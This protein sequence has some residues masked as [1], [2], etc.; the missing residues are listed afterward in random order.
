VSRT[1]DPALLDGVAQGRIEAAAG[2]GK[3]E[4][5]V[6]LTSI[7]GGK[8]TLI[9][10]HT[11]AG[12]AALRRRLQSAGVPTNRYALSS[13]DAWCVRRVSEF[14]LRAGPMPD[15]SNSRVFYPAVRNACLSLLA[16]HAL[17]AALISSYGRV[18]V[19]EYQDCGPDQH[20]IVCALTKLVP[21]FVFGDPLQAVFDFPGSPVVVW[22]RDVAPVFPLL[23]TLDHPWRWIRAGAVELGQWLSRARVLLGDG[24][25]IDLQDLPEGC[26][27]RQ[28]SGDV[29]RDTQAVRTATSYW[30]R[31]DGSVLVLANPTQPRRHADIARTGDGIQVVEN[32]DLRTVIQAMARL[33]QAPAPERLRLLLDLAHSVMTGIPVNDLIRRCDVL[34]RGRSR[35]PPTADE[36]IALEFALQADWPNAE[37]ALRRWAVQ[38]GRR[39]FRREV[40]RMLLDC[41]RST[42]TGRQPSLEE[43]M[44]SARERRRHQGRSTSARSIG[45]TLLLKGLEADYTVLL[46]LEQLS[47]QHVYVALT[48]ATRGVLIFSRM[49]WLGRTR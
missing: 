9:L 15:P 38:P 37:A 14:P 33:E 2:C 3:T 22:D 5:I 36:T 49:R 32:L 17:D 40:L 44:A 11:L 35:T 19:D 28:L 13:I 29:A 1:V 8:R 18:F 12:V 27:W 7:W 4:S 16:S 48:R 21:T 23:V 6:Q 24:T 45:S 26:E 34:Q 47:P 25:G 20:A 31:A 41:F 30:H 46:D 39:V 42:A 10:T 43:A